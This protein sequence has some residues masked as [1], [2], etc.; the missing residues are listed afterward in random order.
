[1]SNIKSDISELIVKTCRLKINPDEIRE[2]MPLFERHGLNLDSID[3]LQIVVAIS[4]NYG[5]DISEEKMPELLTIN[6][7]AEFVSSNI[8]DK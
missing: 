8:P 4:K 1:M 6:R 7:I 5:L 3:A 2:D